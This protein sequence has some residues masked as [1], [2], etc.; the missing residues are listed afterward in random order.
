VDSKSAGSSVA[1]TLGVSYRF[2]EKHSLEAGVGWIGERPSGP[3]THDRNELTT[4][5]RYHFSF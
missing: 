5:L 2:L 3:G 1:L 4:Y